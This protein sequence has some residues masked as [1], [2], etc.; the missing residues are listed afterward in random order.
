MQTEPRAA[1]EAFQD[2]LLRMNAAGGF[3]ASLV[4]S[5]DG[6]PIVTVPSHYDLEVAA[7]MGALLAS[8]ADESQ[9]RV[10]LES[11]DEVVVLGR[12]RKRLILR[13]FKVGEEVLVLAAI[14]PPLV[15]YRRHTNRA[16]REIEEFLTT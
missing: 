10:G 5:R 9:A 13:H 4:A 12:D 7:A 3:Q 1:Q 2:I 14:V 16:I 15:P 8:V 6:L 11:M